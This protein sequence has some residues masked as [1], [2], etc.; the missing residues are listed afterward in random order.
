MK[1]LL[2]LSLVLCL[3]LC[4]C[5]RKK[6]ADDVQETTAQ[7]T[8]ETTVVTTVETTEPPVTEVTLDIGDGVDVKYEVLVLDNEEIDAIISAQSS[9]ILASY[10]PNISSIKEMG[11]SAEYDVKLASL[12]KSDKIISAVFKGSYAVYYENSE[13]GGEVLYTINIDPVTGK[14]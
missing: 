3:V 9:K 10:I 1:K 14:I 5:G 12:Y 7:S 8:E 6:P 2:L 11:G 13:E 4:A